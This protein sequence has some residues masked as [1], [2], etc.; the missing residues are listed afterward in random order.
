MKK[1][2]K[3]I[4]ITGGGGYVGS[5]L[6][7]KLLSLG[8]EVSVFDLFIF[9]DEVLDKHPKLKIIKGDIRDIQLIKNSS[10]DHDVFIHLAC[11][12]NDP[13]FE[14]NPKLGKSINLEFF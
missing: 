5:A 7:P 1:N 10:K 2:F 6:V 14:L 13:R 4:F 12:S 8:Y 3:S 11:I 9:G